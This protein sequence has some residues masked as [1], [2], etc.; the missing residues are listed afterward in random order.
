MTMQQQATYN[1]AREWALDVSRKLE[2]KMRYGAE[3]ARKVDFIPYSVKDGKWAPSHIGWWTNGFWGAELLQMYMLTGDTYFLEQAVRAEKMMDAA[4]ADFKGLSHDVGFQW[5]IQSGVR[6][7]I[8]KNAD[9]FDRTLFAADILAGRFNPNGFI[10]AWNGK[11]KEGWA[12]VDCMMNLSLLYWATRQTGDP[13][14]QLVAMRHA[15]TTM[16]N[17]VREDGSCNHIV[18]FD[19]ETGAFL[20]NPGGQGCQSG[21]SWSR[22]QAWALYGFTISYLSTK[23][24]EYL[25]TAMKVAD[26]VVSNVEKAN[27]LT[28]C[29]FQQPAEPVLFDDA[30]GAIAASGLLELSK[31][32]PAEK[33]AKYF[34]AGV[35]ML[36]AMEREHADW[37]EATPAIFQKC[38]S[39]YHDVPG[40]HI[41][42]NYGDFYLI[43][44]VGKLLGA[45]YLAWLPD[46]CEW[47]VLEK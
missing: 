26:Y 4:L 13:R 34:N 7:G 41:C 35:Q 17:F 47:K 11:G 22:G 10:R 16:R 36:M 40:H 33:A 29:D 12:I 23:K 44:A 31:L 43:E 1:Q 27:W 25:E 45:E 24:P 42:M 20:D 46:T 9:S 37:T 5:L 21:S 8:E 2:K 28:V 15:D 18:C 3:E 30:G 32:A 39:A 38:T 14:Y 19:P 6:Y